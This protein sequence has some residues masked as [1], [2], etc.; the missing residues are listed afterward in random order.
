MSR[1]LSTPASPAFVFDLDGTLLD[2]VYQHVTAWQRAFAEI[3]LDLADGL[4]AVT[5]ETGAGK[6]IFAQ[7]IGLLLGARGD[8]AA[9]GQAA[10]EAY[11]EAELDVPDGFWDDDEVAPLAEVRPDDEPGLEQ[12]VEGNRRDTDDKGGTTR[13]TR[14]AAADSMPSA[15]PSSQQPRPAASRQPGNVV[16]ISRGARPPAE[17]WASAGPVPDTSITSARNAL[18]AARNVLILIV[19]PRLRDVEERLSSSISAARALPEE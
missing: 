16:D 14:D 11:V 18:M 13:A 6:T 17:G 5:G 1:S 10:A 7:A 4:T 2:S 9:I 8:A 19:K 3:G 12:H 15:A